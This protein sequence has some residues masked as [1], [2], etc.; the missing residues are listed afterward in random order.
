[1][2]QVFCE[3]LRQ[4]Y[5]TLL[6]YETRDVSLEYDDMVQAALYLESGGGDSPEPDRKEVKTRVGT[7]QTQ[8]EIMQPSGAEVTKE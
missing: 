7:R 2:R 6:Q 8:A 1:M 3:G 5:K 4:E